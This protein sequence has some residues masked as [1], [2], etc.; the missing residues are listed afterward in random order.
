MTE[1][2]FNETTYLTLHQDVRLAVERGDFRSGQEHYEKYGK[3]EGR[4]VMRFDPDSH[5]IQDYSRLVRKLIV[6]HPDNLDLAMAKA[7]G[8]LTLEIFQESGDK[9]YHILRRYGLQDGYAIYDLACGSG[10]TA[11]ALQR[12]GWLGQY[13][14][15]DIIHDLVDY[16][17]R[18]NPGFRFF[19]HPDYSIFAEDNSQDMIFSWSLFTHLQIEESFLYAKDCYRALKPDGIFIFSFLTLQDRGHRDLFLSHVSELENGLPRVHL[20][21][22][23]DQETITTLFCQM[24]G[25]KLVEFIDADDASATPGG[26]FGQ[27]LAVF[28]K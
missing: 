8:A 21:T 14:G 27:A 12:H 2:S 20:D 16:A 22:F 28:K 18:K 23:L 4:K 10:R 24:L 9:H 5:S 17:G 6:T 15:A 26:S 13:R 7:V 3:A 1:P 25:F 19:V 11:S